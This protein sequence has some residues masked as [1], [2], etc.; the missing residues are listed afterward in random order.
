PSQAPSGP[1]RTVTAIIRQQI[2]TGL[3]LRCRIHPDHAATAVLVQTIPILAGHPII[4]GVAGA[5]RTTRILPTRRPRK[6]QTPSLI[7]RGLNR[8]L[9]P[10]TPCL[11]RK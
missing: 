11:L 10:P 8:R 4:A 3:T 6:F 2:P 1:D 7:I 5:S 9:S